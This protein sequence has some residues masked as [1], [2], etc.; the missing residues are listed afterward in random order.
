MTGRTR[1][2]CPLRTRLLCT[3]PAP[4]PARPRLQFDLSEC[5]PAPVLSAIWGNLA[6][7]EAAGDPD[8]AH[9]RK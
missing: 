8:A 9:Y 3:A 5:R 1:T 6:N 7:A 4:T 2:A